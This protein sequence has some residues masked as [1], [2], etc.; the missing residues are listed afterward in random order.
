[1][2]ALIMVICFENTKLLVNHRFVL[3]NYR[4]CTSM[5]NQHPFQKEDQL[6]V[7]LHNDWD[8]DV[9]PFDDD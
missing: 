9:P 6:L 8:Y 3:D 2:G 1:M 5:L 7:D 4:T